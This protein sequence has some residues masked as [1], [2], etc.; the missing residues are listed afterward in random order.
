MEHL[1]NGKVVIITGA[2]SGIGAASARAL[3]A[4][5]CKVVLAARSTDKLRALA[6]EIGPNALA[7]T[8]DIT[9]GDDV[10]R[11]VAQTLERF[12]RVD[13]LF[14][15]AGIYIPGQVADGE[16]DAWANLI[17]VNVTGV[18]RCVHA[19]LPHMLAQKSGDILVTSSI[20]G[21]IDI[22]WEPIYSAS[23]HAI[24]GFV[25]TLRRQ[26][27][28]ANIRVGALAPGMVANELW[29]LTDTSRD[30]HV[31]RQTCQP[32]FGR[33][34][35]RRHF[36]AVATAPCHHSRFGDGAAESGLVMQLELPKPCP[37]WCATARATIGSKRWRCRRLGP[38][39]WLFGSK[40]VG[41]CASDLK[42][43]LGAALF[44]GDEHRVGYCQPPV[45]PGHEFVGEVVALGEGAGEKVWPGAGRPRHQR[46]DCAVLEVPLLPTRPILDVPGW[47]CVWLPRKTPLARWPRI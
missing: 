23:K 26:V 5:G 8:V 47:R 32:A 3:A 28:A 43:Y 19:V 33:C 39:K 9:V 11:L 13:V 37:P 30:R 18:M 21:F 12:G 41:I 7:V 25:H 34:R 29:G 14:A 4:L 31:D 35:H 38:E 10:A 36:Y 16:P 6:N 44:W 20:S 17:N 22:Q 24:Q 40:Q 46:A 1:L 2:S 27:A 42:C 15:N 45:I